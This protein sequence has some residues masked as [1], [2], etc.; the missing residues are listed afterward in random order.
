MKSVFS[1]DAG[2]EKG[3][4]CKCFYKTFLDFLR[5]DTSQDTHEH[6]FLI[7]EQLKLT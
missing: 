7:L 1:E 3:L 4:L 5:T 6:L 2:P